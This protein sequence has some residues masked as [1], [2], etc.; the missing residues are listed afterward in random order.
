MWYVVMIV[1]RKRGNNIKQRRQ[2]LFTPTLQLN[3]CRPLLFSSIPIGEWPSPPPTPS[4]TCRM[5]LSTVTMTVAWRNPR[6]PAVSRRLVLASDLWPCP[7]TTTRGPLRTAASERQNTL[8][9][10]HFPLCWFFYK[11]TAECNCAFWKPIVCD[12]CWW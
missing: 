11:H 9:T 10:V 12:H 7:K 8:K 2:E 4:R 1:F 6:P 5:P 3:V